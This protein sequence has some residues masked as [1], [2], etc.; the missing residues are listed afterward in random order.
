MRE[1]GGEWWCK[2][3]GVLWGWGLP[4]TYTYRAGP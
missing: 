3:R 4:D 2:A 1:A